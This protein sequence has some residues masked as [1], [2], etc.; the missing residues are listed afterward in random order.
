MDACLDDFL[1]EFKL[2]DFLEFLGTPFKICEDAKLMEALFENYKKGQ[3][4]PIEDFSSAHNIDIEYMKKILK[5]VLSD[6][7]RIKIAVARK[8]CIKQGGIAAVLASKDQFMMRIIF[9]PDGDL[10]VLESYSRSNILQKVINF[11]GR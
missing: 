5:A 8:E 7:S 1:N 4:R 2:S 3:K 11:E 10:I 9:S 6:K